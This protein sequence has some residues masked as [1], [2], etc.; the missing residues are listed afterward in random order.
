MSAY[1][2]A[3]ADGSGLISKDEF[4]T[5]LRALG[6]FQDLWKRFELVLGALCADIIL[7][8]AFFVYCTD[9]SLVIMLNFD[10]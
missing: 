4:Y 8:E 3:D 6:F 2:L 9:L 1:K 7:M 5:L 10:E